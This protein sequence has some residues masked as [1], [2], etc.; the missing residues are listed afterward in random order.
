MP[1]RASTIDRM[2]VWVVILVAAT[3]VGIAMGVRQ[4]M[5]LYVKPLSEDL[6]LGREAFSMAIAIANIVWGVVAPFSGAMSDRWGS[7]LV[8]VCG[9]LATANHGRE[10]TASRVCV[11]RS[12]RQ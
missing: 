4:A 10:C 6:G 7:G 5:G 12:M 9:G 8:V 11:M 3:L 2:P 1:D